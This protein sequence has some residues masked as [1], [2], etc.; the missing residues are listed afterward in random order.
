MASKPTS[1]V[2][3]WSKIQAAHW[4]KE[5]VRKGNFRYSVKHFFIEAAK[6]GISTDD[7]LKCILE[8]KACDW[9][10]GTDPHTHL[11]DMRLTYKVE[12]RVKSIA[13]VVAVSDHDPDCVLITTWEIKR[14]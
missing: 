10:H 14:K 11:P 5:C 4:I 3:K 9:E 13:V 7:A 12:R 1:P 8:G 6:D 2:R